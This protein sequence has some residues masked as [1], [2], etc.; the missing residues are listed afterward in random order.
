MKKVLSKMFVMLVVVMVAAAMQ[1]HA[2]DWSITE[3]QYQ[4]GRL[5]APSFSG[6]AKATTHIITL[7]HA[8]G[9]KYGDNF[10]FADFLNDGAKD[11]FNDN[12]IYSK[13]FMNFSL[14]KIKGQKVGGG[15]LRDVGIIGGLIAA[16]DANVYKLLPGIR[17]AWDVPGFTFL[18]TDFNAY[19]DRSSGVK[20]GGA[21][22]ENNTWYMDICWSYPASNRLT[23]EGHW[24]FIGKRKNEFG[25]DV[26]MSILAQPQIR[27]DIGDAL[28]NDPG[29]L[30]AGLELQFW[31]N[32]L[33]AGDTSENTA[34]LLLVWR[35]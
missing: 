33:G 22:T 15:A 14:G 28:F 27:Y 19:I 35:L 4:G 20:S 32:K 21:P 31:Q 23:I 9:W 6:G 17:L 26:P 29:R 30:F 11:G 2:A 13:L 5:K 8:S 1:C 18:N 24:E 16:T 3:L 7:Q 34:Q 25:S 10:F 12:D